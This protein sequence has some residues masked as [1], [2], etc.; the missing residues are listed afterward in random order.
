MA[1]SLD[2][3]LRR[4]EESR[5]LEAATLKTVGKRLAE[6]T[7]FHNSD[8][9]ADWLIDEKFLT[10]YQVE[11]IKQNR[12][13]RLVL[14][15][16][17]VLDLI[18]RGGM[19]MVFKARHRV[20]DRIVAL[21]VLPPHLA[22]TG[23]DDALARFKREVRAAAI[24]DHP[25]IVAAHDA[26]QAAGVHFLVMQLVDGDNL[27]HMVKQNGPLP[28]EKTLN[29]TIHCAKA[30]EYSHGR[31]VLHR[32][33]KPGNIL[34]DRFEIARI[35]D[36]GLARINSAQSENSDADELT[37]TGT[38][39]GTASFMAPEQAMDIKAADERADIYSLGC[40]FYFAL[41]G[42]AVYP[43]ETVMQKILAHRD[44]PIPSLCTRRPELPEV[45]DQIFARMV[46]KEPGDRYQSM[47]E[48]VQALQGVQQQ[49]AKSGVKPAPEPWQEPST[50]QTFVEPD[51]NFN[52]HP[53]GEFPADKGEPPS[54]TSPLNT[55]MSPPSEHDPTM[56]PGPDGSLIGGDDS[57]SVTADTGAP[58]AAGSPAVS[59]PPAS[60][61]NAYKPPPKREKKPRARGAQP[62]RWPVMIAAAVV[63][64]GAILLIARPWESGN[65][66]VTPADN[67][68]E[69]AHRDTPPVPP[70]NNPPGKEPNDKGKPVGKQPMTGTDNNPSPPAPTGVVVLNTD[71]V[72]LQPADVRIDGVPVAPADLKIVDN[73]PTVTLPPGEHTVSVARDGFEP[74]TQLVNVSK[75]M[76]TPLTVTWQPLPPVVN[77]AQAG[78]VEKVLPG[79][80][81]RPASLPE[82]D[83]WQIETV[84]PRTRVFALAVTPNGKEFAVGT[85]SG[86]IRKYDVA[87]GKPLQVLHGHVG[88]ISTLAF[89]PTGGKLASAGTM[90]T[91]RLWEGDGRPGPV[92]DKHVGPVFG[93]A[94]SPDGSQL[95]SSDGEKNLWLWQVDGTP[96]RM[97][98]AAD[99]DSIVT[100]LAW[101]KNN[102]IAGGCSSGEVWLWTKTDAPPVRCTGHTDV[103]LSVA[104]SPDG[105]T[106]ASTG[107]DGTVRLWDS[108]G[109]LLKTFDEQAGDQ[110]N[111]VV[112]STDGNW[113]AT[114]GRTA[115]KPR[116][117][118]H[119]NPAGKLLE[120]PHMTEISA[121][122]W[123]PAGVLI[124]TGSSS[125]L[126]WNSDGEP[127]PPLLKGGPTTS[128]LLTFA[129]AH[130]AVHVGH[131]DAL[132]E[133]WNADG[134]TVGQLRGPTTTVTAIA[135][136]ADRTEFVT[137]DQ[138]GSAR[139]WTA[140]GKESSHL[141]VPRGF[142]IV[143]VGWLG[144]HA[145]LARDEE[146]D[147]LGDTEKGTVK[148][149]ELPNAE[150]ICTDPSTGRTAIALENQLRI[151]KDTTFEKSIDLLRVKPDKVMEGATAFPHDGPIRAIG[152]CHNDGKLA[153]AADDGTV[154][155]WNVAGQLL[156]TLNFPD[157]K[158]TTLDWS[159]DND[160]L[161]VGASDG[162]V[163]IWK[164]GGDEKSAR[165]HAT[166]PAPIADLHWDDTGENLFVAH[167]GGSVTKWQRD[168][169]QPLWTR[170]PGR[171]HPEVFG[172]GGRVFVAR[173][174]S[175]ERQYQYLL[176]RPQQPLQL[177]TPGE[178]ANRYP[179]AIRSAE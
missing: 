139:T 141:V 107:V 75:D 50:N 73:N 82:G 81:P 22:E 102:I 53:A 26:D 177:L 132:M 7:K 59:T 165:I 164:N 63:L 158:P 4:L 74:F 133:T 153:S 135:W 37:R 69:L 175:L 163:L 42:E 17:V 108:A 176:Q 78:S 124:G 30:L 72:D 152:F 160:W 95:V 6:D 65:T 144:S 100:T 18:G 146:I 77:F 48:V 166:L 12:T 170:L 66:P 156:T 33:I 174:D 84:A 44:Q 55:G 90:G 137:G 121:L 112:W 36:M 118:R 106:V 99:E 1:L 97:L 71:G 76:T 173:T 123:H 131:G 20:M 46:A 151:Y 150:L 57:G 38:V 171:Q 172:S 21:K 167:A 117:F 58:P 2:D 128:P 67:N 138:N 14:G 111:T 120:H 39:M 94:W 155:R 64:V 126:R 41:A 79:L 91:V 125:V 114:A 61:G 52:R 80:L 147:F 161:A 88:Q 149:I 154:R 62:R 34:I 28:F 24:L 129:P 54:A 68:D 115:G 134:T 116:L 98:P 113:L 27:G 169:W 92:F 60:S 105:N 142:P 23:D 16:Y 145:F 3:F 15:N 178:F 35:L 83:R 19:G 32:D 162:R 104:W 31:G 5:I 51:Q 89:D 96:V 140:E 87:E 101:N 85:E 49:L 103:V 127:L 157:A 143:D 109:K 13:G 136:N 86:L 122:A 110:L 43:A 70:E 45:I 25:N 11:A 119:D 10:P 8:E 168:G 148:P 179:T 159:R 29:Y 9:L 130:G 40:T 93:L 56:R 47:S